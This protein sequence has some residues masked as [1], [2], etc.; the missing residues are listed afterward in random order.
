[1]GSRREA[2]HLGIWGDRGGG[3][4]HSFFPPYVSEVV[5]SSSVTDQLCWVAEKKGI[6]SDTEMVFIIMSLCRNMQWPA[7]NQTNY[8][9]TAHALH[10]HCTR[11][12]SHYTIVTF[13]ETKAAPGLPTR[14]VRATVTRPPP[15]G[16][17]RGRDE[18]LL[19]RMYLKSSH[20]LF[21]PKPSGGLGSPGSIVTRNTATAT[22][23]RL[24]VR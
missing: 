1:M 18:F 5:S 6:A 22:G 4:N 9:R 21:L 10:A 7:R 17:V 23:D 3:A 15:C 16:V 12:V 14:K 2:H 11:T 8:T 19:G 13:L 20:V 24:R